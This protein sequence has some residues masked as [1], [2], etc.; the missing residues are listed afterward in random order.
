[1]GWYRPAIT[2]DDLNARSP[3]HL[4][5]LVGV[6]VLGLGEGWLEAEVQI[7]PELFAPNGFLHAGTIVTL[8]DTASGYACVAHLPAGANGFTTL[9]LKSNH[10]GTARDGTIVA[11]VRA[12]HLGRTTQVWDAT[13]T[14]RESGRTVALFRCTQ[15]VL[16]PKGPS[17]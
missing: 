4:P 15:L 16:W 17:A 6:H 12:A 8:A 7:R 1:M 13:V 5:G 10:V 2:A 9:E 3:G 14:H 11:A